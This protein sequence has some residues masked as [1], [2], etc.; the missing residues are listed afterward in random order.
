MGML[1]A[2]LEEPGGRRGK[3]DGV[4][5]E[6]P[7]QRIQNEECQ[8]HA[9]S[10]TKLP[11][12]CGGYAKRTALLAIADS[13][14]HPLTRNLHNIFNANLRCRERRAIRTTAKRLDIH[15]VVDIAVVRANRV[16]RVCE[17]HAS[18]KLT[19]TQ[20]MDISKYYPLVELSEVKA[21]D[22]ML[23]ADALAML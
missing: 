22:A 20:R 10:A 9:V 15:K 11:K 23:W 4:W 6:Y 19:D 16:V 3:Y 13:T 2:E 1:L 17:I 21:S 14:L 12:S 18:N 8:G 7:L 5:L